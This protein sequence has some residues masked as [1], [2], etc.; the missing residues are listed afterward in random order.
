ME[1]NIRARRRFA[2]SVASVVPAAVLLAGCGGASHLSQQEFVTRANAAC[3]RANSAI[4]ALPRPAS[5]PAGLASY[6]AQLEPIT[7]R[8]IADLQALKPRPS[9]ESSFRAYLAELQAGARLLPRL[10]TAAGGGAAT[11]QRLAASLG[12]GNGD[13]IA[14]TLGL[15]TCREH[16]APSAA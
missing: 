6:A 14:A 4:A 8:L 16:P 5:S 7:N 11:V 13:S 9:S 3:A 15:S 12:S 10:Q 2:R 1:G